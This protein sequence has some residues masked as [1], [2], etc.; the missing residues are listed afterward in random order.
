M[1]VLQYAIVLIIISLLLSLYF[2]NYRKKHKSASNLLK[3]LSIT[4][5]VIYIFRYMGGYDALKDTILLQ[6]ATFDTKLSTLLSLVLNWLIVANI[7]LIFLNAFFKIDYV[8][9]IIK[10]VSL[11]IAIINIIFIKTISVGN[12]GYVD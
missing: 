7:L 12:V 6:N 5:F 3:I 1:E 9:Y 11:P 4:L 2:I 10:Y 8:S